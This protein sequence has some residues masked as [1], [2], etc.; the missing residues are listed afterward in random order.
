MPWW[1]NGIM[2]SRLGTAL[3]EGPGVVRM[4]EAQAQAPAQRVS[5]PGPD[6]DSARKDTTAVTRG[7]EESSTHIR[8]ENCFW[9]A[10]NVP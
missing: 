3:L 7:S 9:S 2:Q 10:G 1:G 6:V 8:H 4:A 5:G